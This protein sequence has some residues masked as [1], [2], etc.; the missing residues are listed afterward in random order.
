MKKISNSKDNKEKD[1]LE[2]ILRE[3]KKELKDLKNQQD[4]ILLEEDIKAK[5][6]E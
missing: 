5:I 4:L 3:Y 2:N 6:K 1:S